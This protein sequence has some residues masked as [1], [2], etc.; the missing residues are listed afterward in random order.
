[1][2]NTSLIPWAL[3]CAIRR[4]GLIMTPEQI[5]LVRLTLAQATAGEPSIGREFYRRL[6]V[7][8]PDLRERFQ[9]DVEAEGS[10]LKDTLK[11][12]F[13]SLSDLPFLIATLEALAR[14][15]LARGL[16]DHHCRAISKALLWAIEQR[17]G[18]AAFTPQVCN[19]WIAFLAVVVSILRPAIG[20]G[21]VPSAFSVSALPRGIAAPERGAAESRSAF[22]RRAPAA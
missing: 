4:Q 15:G 18:P 16:P 10:K 20:S 5:Q 3:R 6:F 13:A 14:R 9:G 11:L 17:V 7:L 22:G 12:A 8:A 2:V 19:A 21:V 1:M